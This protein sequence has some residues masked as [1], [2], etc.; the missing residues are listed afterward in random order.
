VDNGID[1]EIVSV[2][3]EAGGRG[4][5][6][7]DCSRLNFSPDKTK[8][9]HIATWLR[10]GLDFTIYVYDLNGTL[11]DKV[12][13]ATKPV[14]KDNN[15]IVYEASNVNGTSGLF[16]RNIQAKS[17]ASVDGT[18]DNA[19]EG[20]IL[21]GKLVYWELIKTGNKGNGKVHTYTFVDK[22]DQVL[23]GYFSNAKWLFEDVLSMQKTRQSTQEEIDMVE[24][25]TGQ[26]GLTQ[27]NFFIRDISANTDV[28]TG[29]TYELVTYYS[30]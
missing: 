27:E 26:F 12:D 1:K 24:S 20:R 23:Q 22:K 21:D 28:D 9:L 19:Y 7:G 14:W 25:I 8:L 13:D 18:V 5:I 4:G 29:K 11:L 6:Y 3:N 17:S 30:E 16:A 15:T 2:Q 10:T